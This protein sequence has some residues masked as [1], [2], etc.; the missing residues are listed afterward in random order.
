MDDNS[1]MSNYKE[2][3]YPG[4][5]ATQFSYNYTKSLKDSHSKFRGNPTGIDCSMG[6]MYESRFS[7]L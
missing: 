2:D 6:L 4:R 1:S 7:A 3:S 5:M